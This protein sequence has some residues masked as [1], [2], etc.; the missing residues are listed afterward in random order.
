[1]ESQ[2]PGPGS[3]FLFSAELRLLTL[4]HLCGCHVRGG[5]QGCPGGLSKAR[6]RQSG[7]PE[8]PTA[9]IR[10]GR[11]LVSS[12]RKWGWIRPALP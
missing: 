8:C 12:T 6:G 2:K 1:M 3:G 9:A 5:N 10:A 11:L 7:P 4:V